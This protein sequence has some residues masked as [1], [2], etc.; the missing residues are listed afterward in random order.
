[1]NLNSKKANLY[2]WTFNLVVVLVCLHQGKTLYQDSTT[3]SHLPGG[4]T[5]QLFTDYTN[6]TPLTTG[7]LR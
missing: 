2:G 4:T 6:M 3:M 5:S 1:M 7:D